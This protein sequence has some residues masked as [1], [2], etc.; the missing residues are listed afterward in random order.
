MVP[1]GASQSPDERDGTDPQ[2]HVWAALMTAKTAAK[3]TDEP[4]PKAFLRRVGKVYPKPIRVPGRRLIAWGYGGTN[5]LLPELVVLYMVLCVR[6]HLEPGPWI[7]VGAAL[8]RITR[9]RKTYPWIKFT[10]GVSRR[11]RS[12][13]IPLPTQENVVDYPAPAFAEARSAA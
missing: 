3:Y 2:P 1:Q 9:G 12:Y 4:S 5:V 6:L 7:R 13:H 8:R 10:D 11:V